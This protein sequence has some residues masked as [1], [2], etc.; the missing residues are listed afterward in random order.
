MEPWALIKTNRM[1]FIMNIVIC[2]ALGAGYTIDILKGRMMISNFAVFI[3]FVLLQLI[4]CSI[5]FK[6]NK[7]SNCFKYYVLAGYTIVY[8]FAIFIND[9]FFTYVFIFPMIILYVLYQD[10]NLMKY[11]GIEVTALNVAKILFQIY[12]G[13]NTPDD[14]TS[15]TVQMAFTLIVSIGLYAVTKL[16]VNITNEKVEKVLEYSKILEENSAHLN[17]SINEQLQKTQDIVD[18]SDNIKLLSE[19]MIEVSEKTSFNL[20]LESKNLSQ[21]QIETAKVNER[22]MSVYSNVRQLSDLAVG[23]SE[24]TKTISTI[25][26]NTNLLAINA[27][28]EA[29]RSGE[30]NQ[31]FSVVAQEVKSLASQSNEAAD[32]ITVTISDLGNKIVNTIKDINYLT[33]HNASQNKVITDVESTCENIAAEIKELSEISS[34]LSSQLKDLNRANQD[35]VASTQIMRD[36]ASRS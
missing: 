19:K 18:F 26:S 24:A 35:I 30:S 7:Q 36:I 5:I 2:G 33:E 23:I 31:G 28:I 32:T 8:C 12:H 11:I 16:T 17:V 29:V 14:V 1:V 27:S 3:T 10:I 34:K 9:T 4:I 25:A 6:R 15:Y 21:L 13:H 20:T 22:I